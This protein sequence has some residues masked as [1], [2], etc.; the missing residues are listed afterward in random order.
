MIGKGKVNA[1][2]F[3]RKLQKI[4]R[5]DALAAGP[6]SAGRDRAIAQRSVRSYHAQLSGPAVRTGDGT[7]AQTRSP[8]SSPHTT[9]TRKRAENGP[10]PAV[11]AAHRPAGSMAEAVTQSVGHWL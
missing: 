9:T 4:S 7:P 10:D 11:F 6:G 1:T 5:S 3:A 8:G 2:E